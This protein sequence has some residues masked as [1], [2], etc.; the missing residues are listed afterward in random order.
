MAR[1]TKDHETILDQSEKKK[2]AGG[3]CNYF[4][5]IGSGRGTSESKSEEKV[6]E[7]RAEIRENYNSV[8]KISMN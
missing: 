7:V 6:G 1:E 5:W 3:S 2:K 4:K 8:H